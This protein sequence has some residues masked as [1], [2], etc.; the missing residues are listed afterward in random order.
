MR[1]STDFASFVNALSGG[2]PRGC[3]STCGVVVGEPTDTRAVRVAVA[4]HQDAVRGVD[5][6]VSTWII[7]A[8]IDPEESAHES[9][10]CVEQG[11]VPPAMLRA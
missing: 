3:L 4:L 6:P 5:Q 9:S 7:L 2:A 10:V 8:R 11:A 1:A